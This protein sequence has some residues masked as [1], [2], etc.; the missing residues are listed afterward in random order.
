[1][2][3][4]GRYDTVRTFPICMGDLIVLGTGFAA[5]WI[6]LSAIT[7]AGRRGSIDVADRPLVPRPLPLALESWLASSSTTVGAQDLVG[8][9]FE[10]GPEARPIL[11]QPLRSR[12]LQA[13]TAWRMRLLAP[14]RPALRHRPRPRGAPPR[15]LLPPRLGT[16]RRPTEL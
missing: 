5:E 10:R 2:H 6:C 13:A 12:P 11:P 8:R 14:R 9:L 1:M 7:F 15:P 3:N 16:L 4:I